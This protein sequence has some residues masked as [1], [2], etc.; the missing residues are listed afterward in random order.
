MLL[1]H[2]ISDDWSYLEAK[3]CSRLG[4]NTQGIVLLEMSAAKF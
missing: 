4:V 3:L 1:Q 2:F